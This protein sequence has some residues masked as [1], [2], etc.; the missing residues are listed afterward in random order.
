M[1]IYEA[2]KASKVK[3]TILAG[4]LTWWT[5]LFGYY[6]YYGI[7]LSLG[8]L[9]HLE[10][11]NIFEERYD[12]FWEDYWNVFSKIILWQFFEWTIIAVLGGSVIGGIIWWIVQ[13]RNKSENIQ[14]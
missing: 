7:F 5:A 13:R 9:P 11:L 12:E 3:E 2:H 8:K 10:Y 14:I 1:T 6:T 4:I